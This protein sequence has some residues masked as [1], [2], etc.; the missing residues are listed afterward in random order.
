[1]LQKVRGAFF[2]CIMAIIKPLKA[3]RPTPEFAEKVASLPYDVMNSNEARDMAK[4]TP[5]S[6]LHVVKA[7]IDL[8]ASTDPYDKQVY[9]KARDNLNKLIEDGILVQDDKA[10]LYIYKEVM[11]GRSQVGLVIGASI[12]DYLNA[13]IKIHEFT[14]P[15][16]EQDR[17]NYVDYC[18]ANTGLIFLTYRSKDEIN[19]IV[20]SWVNDHAA[21]YDFTSD[22]G[23]Q[24][25]VW[26]IDDD[27]VIDTLVNQ[28]AQVES[29]YVADGHHRSASA[30][31]V[32]K[33]RREQNPNYTGDEPFNYFLSVLFPS[34]ELYVMDYNRVVKDL[35]GLSSEDFLNKVNEKFDVEV[36]A[37]EGQYKPAERHTFGMY[38]E[39]KWYKLTA[40]P[41]SYDE[42]DPIKRLDVSILQEN[43][44]SPV[45][46]IQD[47]KTDKRIDFVGGIRGLQELERRIAEGMKVAFSLYPTSIDDV[48]TV[49]DAGKTM[50]PKS[51]WFEPKLRSGLFVHKL[52]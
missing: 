38:L 11:E 7:E 52:S 44:L 16:K 51:T 17:I 19:T 41:E 12:D 49:A 28:F 3:I 27:N 23:I 32:G 1:M 2:E 36:Y 43:L 46:R 47:P 22:D 42:N 21:V 31:K 18:D 33:M 30:A 25:T 20:N 14:R 4:D 15:D 29:L 45:L 37:G 10:R 48:M 39:G 50:P 34:E 9:E 35:N 24:H 13:V 26:V 8:D 5:H 6:F 40:K